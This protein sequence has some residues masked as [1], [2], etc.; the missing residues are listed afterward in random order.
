[1][2]P[3]N[4]CAAVVLMCGIVLTLATSPPIESVSDTVFV[5]ER[6]VFTDDPYVAISG[7]IVTQNIDPE[8]AELEI[9]VH[10]MLTNATNPDVGLDLYVLDEPFDPTVGVPDRGPDASVPEAQISN[11]F[12]DDWLYV[13]FTGLDQPLDL[14]VVFSGESATLR[15]DLQATVY[16]YNAPL[17]DGAEVTVELE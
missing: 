15:T 7:A 16:Y 9:G 10:V 12:V 6:D 13:Q 4:L 14:V 5:S 8:Q 2:K 3:R 11:G 17:P 1:M